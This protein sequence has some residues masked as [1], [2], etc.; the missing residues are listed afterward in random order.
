MLNVEEEL[1]Q[2]KIYSPDVG[3]FDT[4]NQ[5]IEAIP[6][7]IPGLTDKLKIKLKA[8]TD[9]ESVFEQTQ[10]EFMRD[11]ELR[12]KLIYWSVVFGLSID[13]QAAYKRQGQEFVENYIEYG[14]SQHFECY[15]SLGLEILTE[16]GL[17]NLLPTLEDIEEIEIDD[18]PITGIS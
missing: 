9:A 8:E 16:S 6:F 3:L 14:L 15:E 11:V 10:N 5:D 18:E 1:R 12:N 17:D 4:K 2:G 13:D 7:V